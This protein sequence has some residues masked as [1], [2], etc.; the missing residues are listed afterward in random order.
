METNNEL[1]FLESQSANSLQKEEAPLAF[2]STN[3]V[4]MQASKS[5]SQERHAK[6]LAKKF[7]KE[8][9]W[10]PL[11]RLFRR[12]MKKG[13]LEK[14]TLLKIRRRPLHEQGKL[15]VKKL[16]LPKEL[17][18]EKSTEMAVLLLVNSLMLTYH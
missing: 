5:P 18:E 2:I 6:P 12:Y 14:S 4:Q 1:E 7:K 3:A 17:V 13:A 15:L 9:F 10:K 8:S 11:V 16:K